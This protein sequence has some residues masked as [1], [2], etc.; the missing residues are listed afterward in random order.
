M[1]Y[2]LL[3]Q[4]SENTLPSTPLLLQVLLPSYLLLLLLDLPTP[5]QIWRLSLSLWLLFVPL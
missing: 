3:M 1:K 5:F 2:R 4:E